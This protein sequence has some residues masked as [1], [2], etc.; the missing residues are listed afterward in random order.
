MSKR[1]RH[2]SGFYAS[3]LRDD[4]DQ[5]YDLKYCPKV[6]PAVLGIYQVERIVAK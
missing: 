5:R 3:L 1:S 6:K 2:P 4:R